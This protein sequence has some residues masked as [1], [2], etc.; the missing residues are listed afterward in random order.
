MAARQA[1]GPF[2]S[3]DDLKKV[4]GIGDCTC[5]FGRT[6]PAPAPAKAASAPAPL[7]QHRRR[8]PRPRLPQRLLL[9][10]R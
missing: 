9:R 5:T 6:A 4:N 3:I 8:L 1:N 2:K 10:N 7:R